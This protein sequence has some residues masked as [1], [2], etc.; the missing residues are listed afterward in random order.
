[1]KRPER[2]D[3]DARTTQSI[4]LCGLCGAETEAPPTIWFLRG[5]SAALASQ[6]AFCSVPISRRP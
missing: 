1:M 2:K 4:S 5:N 3:E 6:G